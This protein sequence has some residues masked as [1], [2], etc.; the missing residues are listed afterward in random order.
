MG[1]AVKT[2][3]FLLQCRLNLSFR[4]AGDVHTKGFE[5]ALVRIRQHYGG[6]DFTIFQLIQL[7]HRLFRFGV[8]DCANGERHQH[9]VRMQARVD[10][11]HVLYLQALKGLDDG[12][13]NQLDC[14]VDTAKHL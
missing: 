3:R 12:G 1:R 10:R 5:G 2:L 7:R 11:A 6:V 14:V 4:L 13:G 9:F 8:V